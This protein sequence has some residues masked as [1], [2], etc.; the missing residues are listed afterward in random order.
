MAGRIEVKSIT[1]KGNNIHSVP[2]DKKRLRAAQVLF[3]NA[4][5]GGWGW[6]KARFNGSVRIG[7]EVATKWSG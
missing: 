7:A 5:S 6:I 2:A 4:N 1:D 3:L